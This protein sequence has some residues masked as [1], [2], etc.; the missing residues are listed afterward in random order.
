MK[1]DER[2]RNREDNNSTGDHSRCKK[3]KFGL[4]A[5]CKWF[6]VSCLFKFG[7]LL[8]KNS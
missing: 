4:V 1:G 5:Y 7:N 8:E 2:D 6:L 3:C